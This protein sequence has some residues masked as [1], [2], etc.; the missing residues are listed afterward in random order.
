MN[1]QNRLRNPDKLGKNNF[2]RGQEKLI[3]ENLL[4]C[5]SSYNFFF[6]LSM[7]NC[8]KHP[9]TPRK[10][11]SFLPF[12][13]PFPQKWSCPPKITFYGYFGEYYIIFLEKIDKWK[14]FKTSFPSKKTIVIF[15]TRRP[16]SVKPV[17]FSQ[18]YVSLFFFFFFWKY[19]FF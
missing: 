16:F 19:C 3:S 8:R 7:T 1:F 17:M 5:F 4:L 10:C 18:K 9:I 2:N 12:N 15:V 13:A 11:H 6:K 14:I